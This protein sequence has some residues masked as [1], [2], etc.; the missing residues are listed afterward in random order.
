[1]ARA[2]ETHQA[3]PVHQVAVVQVAFFPVQHLSALVIH[4]L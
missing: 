4:L 1:V 2:V 3:T